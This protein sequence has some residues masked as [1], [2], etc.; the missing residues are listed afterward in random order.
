MD[1]Q[2]RFS[3][4]IVW[5]TTQ[6]S[7]G[8]V[9]F[10]MQR[11]QKLLLSMF[12]TS[13]WSL[14]LSGYSSSYWLAFIGVTA[15]GKASMG[16]G[17]ALGVASFRLH[18]TSECLRAAWGGRF[19]LGFIVRGS[20]QSRF[21]CILLAASI[22]VNCQSTLN[23]MWRAIIAEFVVPYNDG[24]WWFLGYGPR[25]SVCYDFLRSK[26]FSC[27]CSYNYCRFN[28]NITISVLCRPMQP[29][30]A[31]SCVFLS[32]KSGWQCSPTK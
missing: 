22:A 15:V 20:K 3:L 21:T 6:I 32:L 11:Y 27:P 4:H 31:I 18:H 10:M 1:S 5:V 25:P 17:V 19:R 16:S 29:F 28:R 26:L 30:P 24:N 7:P 23:N 12:S 13:S 9:R 14:W 2:A 8:M